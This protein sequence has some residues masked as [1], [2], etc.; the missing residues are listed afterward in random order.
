MLLITQEPS[1]LLEQ[2]F[3]ATSQ[4]ED[5]DR[6]DIQRLEKLEQEKSAS[7]LGV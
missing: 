7:P 4:Q 2:T 5:K 3:F 6:S 1:A